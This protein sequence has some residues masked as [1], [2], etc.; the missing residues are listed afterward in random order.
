MK[1]SITRTGPHWLG[2]IYGGA[3][4]TNK[5]AGLSFTNDTGGYIAGVGGA[6]F[7]NDGANSRQDYRQ[8][9]DP[10][11]DITATYGTNIWFSF[12][13]TYDAASG[14]G[15]GFNVLESAGDG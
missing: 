14:S 11:T 3:D 13:A 2:P 6:I 12:L 5:A 1:A 10:T 8:W 4:F 7:D 15:G 9:F